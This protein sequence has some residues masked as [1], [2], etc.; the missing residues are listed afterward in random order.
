MEHFSDEDIIKMFKSFNSMAD[1]FIFA[2]P[3]FKI[4]CS[5]GDE[6]YLSKR[7][8]GK[9]LKAG[10]WRIKEAFSY[11]RLGLRKY[12]SGFTCEHTK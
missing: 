3:N 6:R 10:G 8:W 5:Y 2:V 1:V 4:P 11:N 7:H 12:L 9:L